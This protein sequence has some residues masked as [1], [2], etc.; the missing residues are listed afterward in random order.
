[1]VITD[2][3]DIVPLLPSQDHKRIGE[4]DTGANTGGMG[5]YTPVPAV[6]PAVVEEALERIVRP[7]I[8]AIA[9][10]GIPYMGVLYAGIMITS[11]GI[12][13][14]EF[15]CRL[16]DPETQVILPML[17]S[18]LVPLLLGATEG[19]LAS[20]PVKW[21]QGA[22]TCVVAASGGYPSTFE[23]GKPISGLEEANAQPNCA[24]FHAGTSL[25]DDKVVTSGGRVLSVTGFGDT[26][27][28][29][30]ANAYL[31]VGCIQFENIYY[32]HDI[33]HRALRK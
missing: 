22:S 14:I 23:I 10:L 9:E 28:D 33:A 6:P 8:H 12:K 7:A 5:A 25:K 26:V 24:V 30:V 15:N 20:V 32:R 29:S 18:D 1:M 11:E 3:K 4:G 2:G 27:M 17:E 21:R 13:T 19:N 31:G 16:G